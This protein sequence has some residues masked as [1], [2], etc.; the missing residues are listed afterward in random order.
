YILNI[1]N[2]YY[3]GGAYYHYNKQN[4]GSLITRYNPNLYDGWM[5]LYNMMEDCIKENDLNETFSESLNNRIILDLM[6][7]MRNIMSS[8]LPYKEK[9]EKS[10]SILS[11]V[12]YSKLFDKFEFSCLP[13]KWRVF[14]ELCKY[15]QIFL[16]YSLLSIAEPFK[17]KLK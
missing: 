10:F 16:I 12:L 4:D 14:F 6:P 8:K 9:R 7:L 5:N 1:S 13:V 2:A 3:Y 11:N 17:A 15:K